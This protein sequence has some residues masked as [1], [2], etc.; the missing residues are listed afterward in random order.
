[1]YEDSDIFIHHP[2]YHPGPFVIVCRDRDDNAITV[3]GRWQIQAFD[4]STSVSFNGGS[5]VLNNSSINAL[6]MLADGG[7]AT[8]TID[9]PIEGYFTCIV[10]NISH[11]V[12]ILTG[13][14]TIKVARVCEY[15]RARI[16][17]IWNHPWKKAFTNCMFFPSLHGMHWWI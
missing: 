7:R 6:A 3:Q 16:L 13:M 2:L 15:T 9:Q 14:Q 5:V 1:M 8:L 12:R 17:Y 11:R 4:N 10:N